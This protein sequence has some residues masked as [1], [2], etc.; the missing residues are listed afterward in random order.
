[1]IARA[2]APGVHERMRIA[3]LAAQNALIKRTLDAAELTRLSAV[4]APSRAIDLELEFSFDDHRNVRMCG[5]VSAAAEVS[6]QRCL[7]A[8]PIALEGEFDVVL[9]TSEV[10]ASELGSEHDV[11][12]LASDEATLADLIED[13]LIL[14]LPQQPCDE[15]QCDRQ[16]AYV[17]PAD[18][19]AAMLD[20]D[21]RQNNPFQVL[22]Q[23]KRPK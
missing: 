12:V 18:V 2:M 4:C 9:V 8:V 3:D 13:E 5:T 16:P 19:D 1:M 15:A 10:R 7:E 6:C 17:Y 22:E 11:V 14:R 23:L 21:E 20:E